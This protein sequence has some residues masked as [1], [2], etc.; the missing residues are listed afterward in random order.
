MNPKKNK[1]PI[2]CSSEP[3]ANAANAAPNDKH[4]TA[5]PLPALTIPGPGCPTCCA[6]E[7]Y[8]PARSMR[9]RACRT[10]I[11]GSPRNLGRCS[12]PIPLQ[13]DLKWQQTVRF[14]R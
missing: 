11:L 1:L 2:R 5:R 13:I 12:D 9:L 4:I 10:C 7:E 14:P 3:E 8:K 6:F